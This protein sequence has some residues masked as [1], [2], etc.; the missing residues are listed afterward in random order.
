MKRMSWWDFLKIERIHGKYLNINIS[1]KQG[2]IRGIEEMQD[3]NGTR[4]VSIISSSSSYLFLDVSLPLKSLCYTIYDS[5]YLLIFCRRVSRSALGF[6]K[7]FLP[8]FWLALLS[9]FSSAFRLLLLLNPRPI[10][11]CSCIC[12]AT[13]TALVLFRIDSLVFLPST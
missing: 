11:T 6:S 13:S 8:L 1:H 4:N 7:I 5:S 10:A 12:S 2:G 3:E 9:S